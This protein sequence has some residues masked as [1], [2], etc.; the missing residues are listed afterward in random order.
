MNLC[1]IGQRDPLAFKEEYKLLLAVVVR[2]L[3]IPAT[4]RDTLASERPEFGPSQHGNHLGLGGTV[5][6]IGYR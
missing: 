5:H 4:V 1:V 6:G 3:Q 2:R